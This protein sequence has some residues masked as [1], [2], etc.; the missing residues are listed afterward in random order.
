MTGHRKFSLIRAAAESDDTERE[1]DRTLARAKLDVEIA[2]YEATLAELR[3]ARGLTQVQLAKTLNLSQ[4]QVS[5][6]EHQADVLLSTIRSYV[7]ALGGE[8]VVT[9]RFPEQEPVEVTF[10]ELI[11]SPP[12]HSPEALEQ[13]QDVRT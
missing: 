12:P 7:E 2:A 9:A 6:V 13:E 10:D 1:L 3:R 4:P 5:R 11:G 8:V